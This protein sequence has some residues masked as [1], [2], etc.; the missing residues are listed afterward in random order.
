MA[1]RTASIADLL[2]QIRTDH[3]LVLPDIQRDFVWKKSQIR[4]LMDSIMR[5]YPFGSLLFWQTRY[6][7]V[8]YREFVQDFRPGQTFDTKMKLEGT[9]LRMVLDGQ[10]RLQSLFLGIYGLHDGRRLC[11]DVTSGPGASVAADDDG[12]DDDRGDGDD[13]VFTA[14]RFGFW[15][16][17]NQNKPKRF[18]RVADIVGWP[19]RHE[20]VEIEKLLG[21]L[22]LERDDE[23]R[24]TR[25]LHLLRRVI[26]RSDYVAVETIVEEAQ[27]KDSARTVDEILDV[28]VRVNSGG[29]RLSRSDLMFSLLKARSASVRRNFDRLVQ[30]VDRDGT[31]GIDKDFVIRGLLTVADKPPTFDIANIQNHR[32]AMEAAFDPFSHAIKTSI[33]FCR[34][35]DV[36]L[37][38]ASLIHPVNTL[39]PVTYYL[40][41][42]KNA[43]VPDSERSSL[44]AVVS[45]L[46]FNRFLSSRSPEARIRYLREV[47]SKHKGGALP[48]E[49]LLRVIAQRQKHH[50][51]TTTV[52]MLNAEPRLALN[53]AQPAACR[54]TLAWQARAEVDH[55]FP[56]SVWRPK[57]GDAVDDIGN[58]AWLGK[59]RNIR[60]TDEEP[61]SYFKDVPDDELLDQYLVQRELLH[62]D[63]FAECIADRRERILGKVRAALGR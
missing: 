12:D 53:L 10:Q 38:S 48:L 27:S 58:F 52:D 46:L 49:A 57:V 15:N 18:V 22:N 36:G 43:S 51:V 28:F 23:R 61:A 56:Q 35:P 55:I 17:Q 6:L 25:N 3:Q 62:P 54:D 9:P 29:T 47:L 40:A 50:H 45:F 31:L 39:H 13:D 44:R 8:A 21:T 41:H 24:A 32:D 33:D 59:L 4:L 16:D 26:T 30:E 60:K 63:R 37:L 1:T 20:D 14:Y 2:N 34:S 7:E 19:S 5:E 42:F 11:F